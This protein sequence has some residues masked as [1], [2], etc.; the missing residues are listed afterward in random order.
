MPEREKRTVWIDLLVLAIRRTADAEEPFGP[1]E[2]D[3]DH[4]V[5][6]QAEDAQHRDL[7]GQLVDLERQKAGGGHS[8]QVFGPALHRLQR[9]NH[10]MACRCLSWPNGTL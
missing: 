5:H 7:L 6:D 2:V 8:G 4:H 9:S 10:P 1:H 3:E